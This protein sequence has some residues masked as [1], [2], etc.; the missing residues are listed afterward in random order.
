MAH[1]AI[2]VFMIFSFKTVKSLI[3]T[4]TLLKEKTIFYDMNEEDVLRDLINKIISYIVNKD[5]DSILRFIKDDSCLLGTGK[6]EISQTPEIR[7]AMLSL[8]GITFQDEFNMSNVEIIQLE[9]RNDVAWAVLISDWSY[10]HEGIQYEIEKARI[11]IVF[12]KENNQ[13]LVSQ[14][15]KS[16]LKSKV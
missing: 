11:S 6:N 8:W 1:Y 9:V 5:L 14:P 2:M 15:S 13:W 7:R 12:E 16:S 10:S 4:K 3:Q